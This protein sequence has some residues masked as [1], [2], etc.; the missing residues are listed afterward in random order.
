MAVDRPNSMVHDA[1]NFSENEKR[2]LWI[3]E[4]EEYNLN[5][6]KH[7]N[8]FWILIYLNQI[9]NVADGNNLKN[10]LS[11]TNKHCSIGLWLC[12]TIQD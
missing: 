11:L 7:D 4:N 10:L 2:A 8:M 3:M 5:H 12:Y 6:N 1:I 9:N